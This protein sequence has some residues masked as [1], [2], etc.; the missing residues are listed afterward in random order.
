M[1]T[2]TATTRKAFSSDDI[3]ALFA[4]P[5]RQ[6]TPVEVFEISRARLADAKLATADMFDRFA[7]RLPADGTPFLLVPPQPRPVSE[8]DWNEYMA[9]IQLNGKMGQNFLTVSALSDLD[10]LVTVPRMLVGVEDG[11][12]RLNTKP[13]VAQSNI[14]SAGRFGYGLWAGYIHL[15]VFSEV[16]NHHYMD[17]VRSR[18]VSGGVPCLCL[19]GGEPALLADWSDGAF[20]GWGAPSFGSVIEG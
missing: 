13:S 9:R 20:P 4:P 7:A 14:E 16:L 6:L 17:L 11:R 3:G 19:G 18:F 5:L 12:Q 8:M 1:T 10:P 2:Q 15:M